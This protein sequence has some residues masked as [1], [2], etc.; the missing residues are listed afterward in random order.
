MLHPSIVVRSKGSIEGN[1]LFTTTLIPKET[2]VWTLVEPTYTLKEVDAWSGERLSDFKRYGFQ[3]GVNRF[4][5]PMGMSR[6][7]NHS[8]DPNTC[9]S[10]S[11]TMIAR[12]DILV[13]EEITYDY[14]SCDIDID[15]EM[16]CHCGSSNCR[17]RISNRDYQHV[18]WQKQYGSDLPPHVL[19]AIQYTSLPLD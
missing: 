14:S 17:G 12:R 6:E 10:T 19:L 13:D 18:T 8:C 15:F 9:W 11:D 3:C 1:G 5:L 16:A 7:M 2:L 4:S